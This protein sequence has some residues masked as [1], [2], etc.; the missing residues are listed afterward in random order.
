MTV[1]V[2]AWPVSR[3]DSSDLPQSSSASFQWF[4][5][6]PRKVEN[7][8]HVWLG[9]ASSAGKSLLV[10]VHILTLRGRNVKRVTLK[11]A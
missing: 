11:A 3:A 5:N 10:P 2:T 7:D 6:L 8:F 1:H 4:C 9:V